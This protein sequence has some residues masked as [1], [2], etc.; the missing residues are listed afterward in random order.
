VTASDVADPVQHALNRAYRYLAP[1]DRST[2]EMRAHLERVGVEEGALEAA[3]GIL[4]EL[5][6]LDDARFA[7]RFTEDKRELNG[8][9]AERIE[10]RLLALGI[11][12]D[13]IRAALA[14]GSGAGAELDRALA[15]LRRRFP[16]PISDRRG[17][18]RA[19]GVLLRKGYEPELAFEA[20]AAHARWEGPEP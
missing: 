9:G 14:E 12:R 20:L 17:R 7:V 18:D 10:Q 8:W 4:T 3:V 1:R 6:Y 16:A 19:L 2:H 15:L 13:H 11:D 5:G